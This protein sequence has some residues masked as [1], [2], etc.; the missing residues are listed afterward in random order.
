MSARMIRIVSRE[1]D[2]SIRV[3]EF[4]DLQEIR[5]Q[6]EQIGLDDC[7]TELSLRGYPLFRGLIGPMADGSDFA[8]YETPG[9]FEVLTKEWAVAKSRR[10]RAKTIIPPAHFPNVSLPV[11][12]ADFVSG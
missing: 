3:K 6:Y 1:S 7:N 2:G 10:R 5:R 11:N 4:E 12:S 9:V 8:R